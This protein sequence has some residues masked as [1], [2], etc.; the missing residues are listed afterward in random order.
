MFSQD[1]REKEYHDI[2]MNILEKYF[3]H[4]VVEINMGQRIQT[5]LSPILAVFDFEQVA[6]LL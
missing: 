6:I 3:L 1:D 2:F 5:Q 4:T